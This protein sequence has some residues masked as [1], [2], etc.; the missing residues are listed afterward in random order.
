MNFNNPKRLEQDFQ[1]LI[2]DVKAASQTLELIAFN[3]YVQNTVND[4]AAAGQITSDLVVYLLKMHALSYDQLIN[5]Y[6]VGIAVQNN[7]HHI[8]TKRQII[9]NKKKPN[10]TARPQWLTNNTR[11][12]N[13][14]CEHYRM[15]NNC[16][17]YWCAPITG[18]KCQG[19]WR[20]HSP[21]E[22]KGMAKGSAGN[23]EPVHGNKRNARAL[24][25]ATSCFSQTTKR[26]RKS[27]NMNKVYKE[28]D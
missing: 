16:K 18:G 20:K 12:K 24:H 4:L 22:C 19:H 9:N 13:P 23:K 2:D 25:L 5:P 3:A 28:D 15:W 11:P 7:D 6:H 8:A 17:W 27:H 10:G 21:F 14:T 1:T 26:M